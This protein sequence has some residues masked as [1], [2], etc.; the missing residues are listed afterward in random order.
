MT[1]Q[2]SLVLL[3]ITLARE[4]DLF[5]K[6]FLLQLL[7]MHVRNFPSPVLHLLDANAW[8]SLDERLPYYSGLNISNLITAHA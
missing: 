7:I 3:V 4:K 6:R 2:S 8:R 5:I 1:I